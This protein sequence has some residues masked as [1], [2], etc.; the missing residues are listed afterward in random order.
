MSLRT[1]LNVTYAFVTDGLEPD[2]KERVDNWL[3]EPFDWELT[4]LELKAREHKRQL[5]AEGKFGSERG[6][7]DKMGAGAAYRS[8]QQRQ[9]VS[10]SGRPNV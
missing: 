8:Q 1:F 2:V 10:R 3:V 9:H 4:P 7:L 5:E 6:L